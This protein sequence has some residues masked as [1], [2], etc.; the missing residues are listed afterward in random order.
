V[1]LGSLRNVSEAWGGM[2]QPKLAARGVYCCAF[3]GSGLCC[4]SVVW[5][6]MLTL[7]LCHMGAPD[8]DVK[9]RHMSYAVR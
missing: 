1:S 7:M 4:M 9:Y 8:A 6:A 2:E 3:G 5:A